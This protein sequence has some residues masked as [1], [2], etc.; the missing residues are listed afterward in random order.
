MR[1]LTTIPTLTA[2][3]ALA[4]LMALIVACGGAAPE[5]APSTDQAQPA[6]QQQAPAQ[7][8]AQQQAAPQQQAPAQQPAQQQARST[9]AGSCSTSRNESPHRDC[10]P[11]SGSARGGGRRQA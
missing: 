3:I 10:C 1:R 2:L 11:H 8:P 9:T 4:S 5:A 7:Q 6:T